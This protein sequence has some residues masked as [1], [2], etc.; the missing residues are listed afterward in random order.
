M[1]VLGE[2]VGSRPI[3]CEFITFLSIYKKKITNF[4]LVVEI[5]LSA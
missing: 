5:F 2:V 1:Q 4:E 3:V